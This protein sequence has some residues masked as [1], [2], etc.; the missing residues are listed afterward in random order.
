MVIQKYINKSYKIAQDKGFYSDDTPIEKH[1][2][3]ILSELFEV[4]EAH[5]LGA[6]TN[7]NIYTLN[8]FNNPNSLSSTWCHL[9]KTGVKDTLEDEITD[10]FIR[11][12]NLS[13]FM[14]V[15]LD[16]IRPYTA[17]IDNLNIDQQILH[18]NQL[19]LNYNDLSIKLWFSL[20]LTTLLGFCYLNKIN[21]KLHIECKIEFNK[22]REH[23]H[24]KKY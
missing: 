3:G 14:N 15:K 21:I 12:F 16:N 10:M 20:V 23:L 13:A 11:I 7:K 4:Y 9:Y 19:I 6:F 17:K 1:I 8:W 2:T 24:G 5:R 18:I 22:T